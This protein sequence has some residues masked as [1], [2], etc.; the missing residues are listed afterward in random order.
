MRVCLDSDF[1]IAFLRNHKNALATANRLKEE[2]ATLY[3]TAM[4]ALELYMKK[5]VK[6]FYLH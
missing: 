3:T 1:L 5:E 4:N 6:G 2:E